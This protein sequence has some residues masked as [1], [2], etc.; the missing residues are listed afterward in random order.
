MT[1]ADLFRVFKLALP[2]YVIFGGIILFCLIWSVVASIW[3][4][5]VVRTDSK[6]CQQSVNTKAFKGKGRA[7]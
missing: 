4:R 3:S 2:Y 5:R 6:P 1:E 7:R